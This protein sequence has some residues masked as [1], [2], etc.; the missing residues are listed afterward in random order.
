MKIQPDFSQSIE[1]H[2]EDF[3]QFPFPEVDIRKWIL[4]IIENENKEP[5][6]INVILCSDEFLHEMNQRYLNHDELTDIITFDY[7][8]DFSNISGDIFISM[9]R[10]IDNASHLKENSLRELCRIIAHGILHLIGYADKQPE[11]KTVM[12]TK[13]NYYLSFIDFL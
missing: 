9:E 7:K 10:V 5:G 11:D 4:F 3:E 13:E 1:F 6:L 12:T 2:F 8:D